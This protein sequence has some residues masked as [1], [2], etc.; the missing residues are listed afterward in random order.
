GSSSIYSVKFGAYSSIK[1][2][3]GT[4]DSCEPY[5]NKSAL[6]ISERKNTS[7]NSLLP[8]ARFLFSSNASGVCKSHST[9][10][11]VISRYSFQ[12]NISFQSLS[13]FS[14]GL[15]ANIVISNSSSTL[16]IPDSFTLS[17]SASAVSLLLS[18]DAP[19]LFR[20]QAAK[21]NK[22]DIIPKNNNQFL[23]L[24]VCSSPLYSL[25]KAYLFAPCA[26][27]M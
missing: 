23:F 16:V 22:T 9:L 13:S 26:C 25:I 3:K 7:G 18:L 6:D 5:F 10:I 4:K 20:P 12:I 17:L 2:F 15:F 1:S 8:S 14:A 27:K 19:S 11:F 24:N 21:S